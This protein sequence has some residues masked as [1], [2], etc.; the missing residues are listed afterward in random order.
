MV[1]SATVMD[2]LVDKAKSLPEERQLAVIEALRE[3]LEEPYVLT[4][5]ELKVLRPLLSDAHEGK[6]LSNA[7]TDEI[8]SK[9][10]S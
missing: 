3:L 5:E 9:P 10:W 7:E 4:D 1:N 8:L 6:N 2:A